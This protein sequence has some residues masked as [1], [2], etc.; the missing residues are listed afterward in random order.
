MQSDKNLKR[1]TKAQEDIY[2]IALT[3]LRNGQKYSHWMWFIFPQ[4]EGLGRSDTARYYAIKNSEEARQY[5]RHSVLGVRLLQCTKAV[6]A[7]E[8]RTVSQIFGYPDDMKFKSSMTLFASISNPDSLFTRALDKYF[9]GEQDS[10]T[11][12]RLKDI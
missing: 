6:L 10:R 1:F 7:I 8:N 2:N 4:I 12:E 9:A 11:L 5:L 3:E